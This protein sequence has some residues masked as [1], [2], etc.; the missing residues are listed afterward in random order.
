M[1]ITL[2]NGLKEVKIMFR[3][4]LLRTNNSSPFTVALLDWT[5]VGREGHAEARALVHPN[6]QFVK[7]IGR[8]LALTRAMK[9]ASFNREERKEIWTALKAKGMRIG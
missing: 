8:R 5:T 1:K 4:S 2:N 9:L 6:D 3:H 7:R